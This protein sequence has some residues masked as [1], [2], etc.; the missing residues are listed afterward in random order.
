MAQKKGM[1]SEIKKT[2]ILEGEVISNNMQKTIVVRVARTL[3]HPKVGKIIKRY[4]NY[5]VHDEGGI[6]RKG[7]RVEIVESRP[8]SKTKHMILNKIISSAG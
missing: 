8:I 3:R 1:S 2:R 7:D 4:K 6:A 5:K